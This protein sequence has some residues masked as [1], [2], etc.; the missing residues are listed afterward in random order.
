MPDGRSLGT[1]TV[2]NDLDVRYG[3]TA[4]QWSATVS[5]GPHSQ[6]TKKHIVYKCT[7]TKL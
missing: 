2:A 5:P 1:K 4:S 6:K 3:V 7:K